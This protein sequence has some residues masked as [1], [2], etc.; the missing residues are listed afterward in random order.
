MPVETSDLLTDMKYNGAF[1]ESLAMKHVCLFAQKDV[2]LR[3]WMKQ[4]WQNKLCG[5]IN[6]N[7]YV[8]NISKCYHILLHLLFELYVNCTNYFLWQ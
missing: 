7:K 4:K 2:C 3:R 5:P 6:K 8:K 1:M